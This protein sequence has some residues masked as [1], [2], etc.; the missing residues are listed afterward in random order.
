MKFGEN[1]KIVKIQTT[2]DVDWK[3]LLLRRLNR[4]CAWGDMEP[5]WASKSELLGFSE[6]FT[7]HT[8]KRT[9]LNG[10]NNGF[11]KHS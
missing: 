10:R 2:Y 5:T 9:P 3:T 1:K 11:Y 4:E 7:S 8:G 6:Q